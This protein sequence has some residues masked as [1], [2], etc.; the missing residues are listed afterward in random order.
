MVDKYEEGRSKVLTGAV[1][2]L[3]AVGTVALAV[4]VTIVGVAA[5]AVSGGLERPC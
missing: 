1:K 3:A 2:A 5:G 4:G